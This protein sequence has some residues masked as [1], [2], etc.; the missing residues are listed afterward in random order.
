MIGEAE[1]RRL[2]ARWEI[3]P[4]LVDL[5]YVLGCFLASLYWEDRAAALRFKGGTCLRK[6][7][8]ADYRFSED[9]DFT[10]TRL[11]PQEELQAA[12]AA[13]VRAAGDEWQIDFGARPIRVE[14]ADDEYGKESYQ[15]RL[16]Y[17]GP[18]QRRGDPRAV[19]L[20]VTVAENLAFDP[21]MRRIIHPYT[22]A[23]AVAEARVPCY[24]LLEML[25][26]KVRAL[27][28]Q[29]QYA[30]SRDL[31]DTSELVRRE[32]V[33]IDRLA[34]ALPGKMKVKG[35]GAA[36]VDLERWA[37]RKWE[38]ELDWERNL[39]H[40]L[41]TGSAD[42]FDSAWERTRFFLARVNQSLRTLWRE[43]HDRLS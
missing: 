37:G 15:A 17:R 13:V 18:L 4:M 31:Y 5:D 24:D 38:F 9:L 42:D 43:E 8:Y 39:R 16:Y 41:P 25:V 23:D 36:E 14:A 33:E 11:I 10:A 29:R 2:A 32:E 12:L 34:A 26:E 6:C 7:Y 20:D 35:L 1:I 40:L 19:R 21:V 28:G 3:D 22:D 30:I 27:A